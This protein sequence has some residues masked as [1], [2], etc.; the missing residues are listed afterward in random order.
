MIEIDLRFCVPLDAALLRVARVTTGLAESN[1][2]LPP[3]LWFMTHVTCRLTVK[4]R[5][6]LRNPTLCN[7]IWATFLDKHLLTYLLMQV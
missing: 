7:R 6:Q 4:N 2:G 5:D 3:G 1:G